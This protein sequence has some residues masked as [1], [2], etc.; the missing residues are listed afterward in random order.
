MRKL[1]E[2][3]ARIP[4]R[5]R[6][7]TRRGYPA[8]GRSE[9]S[10]NPLYSLCRPHPSWRPP[11]PHP[12]RKNSGFAEPLLPP[13]SLQADGRSPANPLHECW[14]RHATNT[15]EVRLASVTPST[16]DPTCQLQTMPYLCAPRPASRGGRAIAF[17]IWWSPH[18]VVVTIKENKDH[19]SVLF[20]SYYHY[21]RMGV[22]LIDIACRNR[23][24]V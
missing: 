7:Y 16:L 5:P 15:S 10:K 22:L 17:I 23:P 21:Y 1:P 8:S 12:R 19:I 4:K 13:P 20:Y 9:P 24:A 11:P 3:Q 18:P 14:N 6:R 2:L